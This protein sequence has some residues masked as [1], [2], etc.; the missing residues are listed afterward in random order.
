MSKGGVEFSKQ[1][2]MLLGA[3]L[4]RLKEIPTSIDLL[5]AAVQTTA[6][7]APPG[8]PRARRGSLLNLLIS[9]YQLSSSEIDLLRTRQVAFRRVTKGKF[10]IV[11]LPA[12]QFG[13]H[14]PGIRTEE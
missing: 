10:V 11:P 14:D 6:A 9:M 4:Q 7:T 3:A 13:H 2:A 8:W 1:E 12:A 5:V